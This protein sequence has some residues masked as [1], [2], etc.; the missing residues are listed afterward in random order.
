MNA[1]FTKIINK[2]PVGWED[3]QEPTQEP[4]SSLHWRVHPL[5]DELPGTVWSLQWSWTPAWKLYGHTQPT[6]LPPPRHTLHPLPGS[7]FCREWCGL[8]LEALSPPAS[9]WW[10][11]CPL[12]ASL[13]AVL[14]Q[15]VCCSINK[16]ASTHILGYTWLVPS[17]ERW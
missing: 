12:C 1:Q 10:C 13:L 14:K 5:V 9:L 4:Q 7:N 17:Q 3:I 6:S 16:K 15:I 2:Q 8:A 11:S